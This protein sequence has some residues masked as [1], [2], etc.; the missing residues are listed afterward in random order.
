MSYQGKVYPCSVAEV[1]RLG[2][3]RTPAPALQMESPAAAP[4]AGAIDVDQDEGLSGP[5]QAS[6]GILPTAKEVVKGGGPL[7]P[8]S[9]VR[10][11]TVQK[12]ETATLPPGPS[13][14]DPGV[15]EL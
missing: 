2:K 13:G 4:P 14:G 6:S 1:K 8:F 11:R 7:R 9:G 5:A 12:S 3:G 10:P 15:A